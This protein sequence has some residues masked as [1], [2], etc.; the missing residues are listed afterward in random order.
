MADTT[1]LIQSVLSGL[2]TGGTSMLTTVF[3]AFKDLRKR[4]ALLEERLGVPTDPRTGLHFEVMQLSDALRKLRREIDSW[5]EEPP[6]WV[7]RIARRSNSATISIEIL[8][9]Y[10]T[11]FEQRCKGILDRTKRVEE[12]LEDHEKRG[13]TVFITKAEYEEDSLHRAE[14]VTK[15]QA[16]LASANG[17][18]R[19]VMGALGYLDDSLPRR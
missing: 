16:S 2:L 7:N 5:S 14:E 3:V 11:R 13:R 10:E 19:G 1:T 9:D 4:V 8:Q 15:I 18:L 6:S 17:C 12:A